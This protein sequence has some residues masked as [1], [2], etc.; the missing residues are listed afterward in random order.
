MM[1]FALA[2]GGGGA[3]AQSAATRVNAVREHRWIRPAKPA[4]LHWRTA[5]VLATAY[6]VNGRETMCETYTNRT[7]SGTRAQVGTVAVDPKVFAFGTR[8][9]IPGYGFARGRDTGGL[10]KGH[11]IDVAMISCEKAIAWGARRIVIAYLEA[12]TK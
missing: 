9:R 1:A 12:P 6:V 10:I 11:R 3:V 5:M 8:F 7:A 4:V 2:C